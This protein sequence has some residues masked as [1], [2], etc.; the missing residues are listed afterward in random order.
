MSYSH[1]STSGWKQLPVE[2]ERVRPAL[3]VLFCIALFIW[4]AAA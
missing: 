2:P 1:N 3:A 4:G